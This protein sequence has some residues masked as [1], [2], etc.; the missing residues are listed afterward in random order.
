[1]M[2]EISTCA[3]DRGSDVLVVANMAVQF[4][5]GFEVET[6]GVV[7]Q[8]E[9]KKMATGGISDRIMRLQTEGMTGASRQR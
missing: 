5:K 6:L 8:F 7:G 2:L 9:E 4:H 3:M 1:M